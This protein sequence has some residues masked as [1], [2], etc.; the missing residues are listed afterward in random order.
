MD[1]GLRD[2]LIVVLGGLVGLITA[3]LVSKINASGTRRLERER[4]KRE[5]YAEFLRLDDV[6]QGGSE[7]GAAR[8]REERLA[9]RDRALQLIFE[10]EMIEPGMFVFAGDVWEPAKDILELDLRLAPEWDDRSPAELL[11]RYL[12]GWTAFKDAARRDLGS[13]QVREPL[14]DRLE[15]R[16][17]PWHRDDIDDEDVPLAKAP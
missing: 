16:F 2:L 10:I 14:R 13:K 17:R 9:A 5:L 3:V 8:P 15:Q 12:D 11:D 7:R 6:M 1:Q 4:W